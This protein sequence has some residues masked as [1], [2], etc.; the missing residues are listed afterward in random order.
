MKITRETGRPRTH[1]FRVYTGI[2][3]DAKVMQLSC[4]H[5]KTW[6]LT[7]CM[8]KEGAGTLPSLD[9]IAFKLRLRP[10]VAKKH[11][12]A[13]VEV[14]LIDCK[15]NTLTPHNWDKYQYASDVS[16]TRV[17]RY[18][19]RQRNAEGNDN[20]TF[21]KRPQRTE[22]REQ[23]T[24]IPQTPVAALPLDVDPI[25]VE[26]RNGEFA[27]PKATKPKKQFVRPTA[28]EVESYAASVGFP[29]IDGEEFL[30]FYDLREWKPSGS[31][32]VMSDWRPAVVTWKKTWMKKQSG[33]PS[34]FAKQSRFQS[35]E[36]SW[37]VPD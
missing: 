12:D 9:V 22:N 28:A 26:G 13:L 11:L 23:R 3:D 2:I 10:D 33:Q 20:E 36:D 19:E 14:G 6:M 30:A 15:D 16:T 4:T 7:L 18:R 21:Q 5:F 8:A 31:R 35:A 27:V 32:T 25:P 24:D 17:E 29:A 1:W 34:M 37:A